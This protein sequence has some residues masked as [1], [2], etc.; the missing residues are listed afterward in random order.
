MST[1]RPYRTCLN[2]IAG[3]LTLLGGIAASAI[4]GPAVVFDTATG[5][6]LHAYMAT[7]RW[8]PASLTKLMTAYV[9]FQAIEAGRIGLGSTVTIG[10]NASAPAQGLKLNP[11]TT[12]TVEEALPLVLVGSIN[13]V[14][15]ALGVAVGGSNEAFLAE[16]NATAR[17][18]G[19]NDT[20]YVNSYGWHDPRQVTSAR[21]MALLTRALVRDFPQYQRFF[22]AR[23]VT[24]EGQE[25]GN[26]N[27]LLG[28][29]A[30]ADGMKTGYVCESGYNLVGTATR[31][32]RR[33]GA[34]VLGAFSEAEREAVAERL[35]EAGF[36]ARGGA[37]VTL[38]TVPISTEPG[39]VDMRPYV[40]GKAKAPAALTSFGTM[41]PLPRPKP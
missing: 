15:E 21:D 25:R 34:V 13:R 6:V 38:D 22:V 2:A 27:G 23:S 1:F 12:F 18:L 39:P 8:H 33:L 32:G 28:R 35:L 11:G 16:M 9:T 10:A 19:M 14:A 26:H 4:A 41:A 31:E 7:T 24:I 20:A 29:F 36:A 30:G 5:E 40:C 3:A 37:T 17:R